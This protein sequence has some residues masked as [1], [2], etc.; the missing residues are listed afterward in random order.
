MKPEDDNHQ[1]CLVNALPRFANRGL[2]EAVFECIVMRLRRNFPD[3]RIGASLKRLAH[4][5][6]RPASVHFPDSRIGAS[7]KPRGR[8]EAGKDVGNF[9]DSRIGASLKP[10]LPGPARAA[11]Q[12]SPIRESGP[13]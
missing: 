9:P 3:S 10:V 8:K 4:L 12:T 7:L 2:I 5:L 6:L 11:G 13:H 1:G